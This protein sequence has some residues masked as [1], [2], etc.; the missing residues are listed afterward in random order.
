MA[1]SFRWLSF[2][3]GPHALT[4]AWAG[5]YFISWLVVW[6]L[7]LRM[8]LIFPEQSAPRQA[9]GTAAPQ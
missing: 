3:G 6:P 2:Y 1:Y 8:V 9:S 7:I 5:V 4:Y